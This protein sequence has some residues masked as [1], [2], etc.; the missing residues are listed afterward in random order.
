MNHSDVGSVIC[1]N[2]NIICSTFTINRWGDF[3]RVEKM[4]VKNPKPIIFTIKKKVEKEP[5]NC[6]FLIKIFSN[7]IEKQ[8]EK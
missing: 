7:L 5:I 1:E 3:Q 6:M 4:I 8:K 2:D